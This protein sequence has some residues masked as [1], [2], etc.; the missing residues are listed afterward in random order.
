MTI[1]QLKQIYFPKPPELPEGWQKWAPNERPLGY[2]I[3]PP[4]S[5]EL[6][7]ISLSALELICELVEANNLSLKSVFERSR[8]IKD[9]L[10]KL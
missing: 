4:F 7:G 8:V 6:R 5:P 10:E 9:Q 2:V 3:I 1:E